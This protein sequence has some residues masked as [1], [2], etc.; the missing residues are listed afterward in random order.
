MIHTGGFHVEGI[1][2]NLMQAVGIH[3]D[4]IGASMLRSPRHRVSL[5]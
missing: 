5:I 3:G 1:C 2:Y 4:V